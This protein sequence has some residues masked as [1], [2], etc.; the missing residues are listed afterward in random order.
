MFYRYGV[1]NPDAAIDERMHE[2]QSPSGEWHAD[3][4]GPGKAVPAWVTDPLPA[5]G[6]EPAQEDIAQCPKYAAL[7]VLSQR[8]KGGVY[9]GYDL[10]STDPRLCVLK[11]GRLHGETDYSG[12]D[13]SLRIK[14][15][16]EV[17]ESLSHLDCVPHVY[18]LVEERGNRYLKM[19]PIAGCSLSSTLAAELSGPSLRRVCLTLIESIRSIHSSGWIWS[20]CKPL[21]ILLR[22]QGKICL[23]DFEGA[24]RIKFPLLA[25]YGS[26]GY[27]APDKKADRD[28]ASVSDDI[29]AAGVVLHELCVAG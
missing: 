3:V 15:E 8:G 26:P 14:R 18:G 11:E 1:V 20:D 17:L 2:I 12:T 5:Y 25:G 13:G 19:Q 21:N 16:L 7:Q 27:I 29:F 22:A 10:E 28:G 6:G 4:R 9:L 24:C 23:L